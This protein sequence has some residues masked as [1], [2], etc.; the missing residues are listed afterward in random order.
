[1]KI[2]RQYLVSLIALASIVISTSAFATVIVDQNFVTTDDTDHG[3]GLG[4]VTTSLGQTFEV[5]VS[6]I[7]AGV[8]FNVLKMSNTSGDLTVD[9]R[10][11]DGSG[12]DLFAADALATAIVNNS[13]IGYY[14]GNPYSWSSIYVDFSAANISVSMG[15]SLAFVLSSPIGQEFGVQTDYLDGYAGGSRWSQDGD[16]TAFYE[17]AYADLAFK[18]YVDTREVPAPASLLLFGVGLAGL[19]GLR[20]KIS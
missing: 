10:Q 19:L 18:T 15:D 4:I 3:T 11:L 7:L 5:G 12:P 6:G 1:M 13:D 20:R 2:F 16:G 17:L 14:G 8:E 9:I